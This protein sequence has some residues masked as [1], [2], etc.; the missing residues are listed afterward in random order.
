MAGLDLSLALRR[1]ESIGDY[2]RTF[3]QIG[4]MHVS[5][6]DDLRAEGNGIKEDG[7]TAGLTD[8]FRENGGRYEGVIS[9]ALWGADYYVDPDAALRKVTD[10]IRAES[11]MG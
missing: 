3:G 9:L 10:Q 6:P 11:R 1:G 4:H 7:G 8:L 5:G 2:R